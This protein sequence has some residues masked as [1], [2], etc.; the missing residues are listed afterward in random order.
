MDRS[1]Q[2]ELKEYIHTLHYMAARRQ[3]VRTIEDPQSVLGS[4]INYLATS[5]L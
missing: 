5:G 4:V 2:K 1:R 3:R